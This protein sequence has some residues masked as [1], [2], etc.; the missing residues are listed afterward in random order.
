[1]LSVKNEGLSNAAADLG[2]GDMLR[3][4]TDDLIQER[5]KKLEQA[6][7]AGANIGMS[8]ATMSLFGNGGFGQSS[9]GGLF[10]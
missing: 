3:E 10:G 4:Q 2:L 9:A 7:T 1:M 6:Q 5:K 8:P